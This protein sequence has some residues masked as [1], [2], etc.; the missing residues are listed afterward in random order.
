MADDR[1]HDKNR[2]IDLNRTRALREF[3]AEM[4]GNPKPKV[5]P[6]PNDKPPANTKAK[7]IAGPGWMGENK[8]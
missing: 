6:V 7:L 1:A 8:E 5:V 4:T 2:V 3:H